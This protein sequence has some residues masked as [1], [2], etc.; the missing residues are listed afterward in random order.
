MFKYLKY[1]GVTENNT[2]YENT[3]QVEPGTYT[4]FTID[5]K[6]ITKEQYQNLKDEVFKSGSK[7]FCQQEFNTLVHE[8]LKDNMIASTK[9]L[10]YLAVGLT[11]QLYLQHTEQENSV[12][13]QYVLE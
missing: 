13:I 1:G 3:E 9:F 11:Q 12:E 2:I 4:R 7:K 10:C 6:Q 8:S 5:G